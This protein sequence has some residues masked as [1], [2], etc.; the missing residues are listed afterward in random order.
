M[1]RTVHRRPGYAFALARSSDRISKYEYM[2][3]ENLMP[4]FQGDGAYYL[5]LSGQDQT[6]AY[7]VD[8]FTTVSPYGLAG[9]TAPVEE[10]R[11]VPELYGTPYYDN[12]GHPLNFTSSSESQNTYVYFP[13]GTDRH[14]GGAVLG[15]YGA[16]GMVQSDDVAVPRQAGGHPARR[17]RGLPQRDGDEVV[18][19]VR[20]RDRRPRRR[21]R[22]RGR[23]G[24][25][26]D[27]RRPHRRAGRPGHAHR[28]APRRPSVVRPGH[29]RPALA[30]L[31][32]R[33]AAHRRR[34]RL[35]RHP[36]GAGS[37]STRS[38]AAAAWSAPRTR[39]PR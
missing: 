14:S 30:A 27:R 33:D 16:A 32:Q 10:R 19:P 31:R 36:A 37:R 39:T 22:R 17:L 6:Q 5:Y 38:P 29:R 35:P 11:T 24:R 3:G 2:S 8:Y 20:R 1:D 21:G 26:H 9:V 12:P 25:D 4:W 18:V 15:A 34:L 28:G 23:A 7:G 13:R